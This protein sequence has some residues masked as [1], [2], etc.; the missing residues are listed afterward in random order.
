MLMHIIMMLISKKMKIVEIMKTMM[1]VPRRVNTC[2]HGGVLQPILS[3]FINIAPLVQPIQC[4]PMQPH[5]ISAPPTIQ[6]LLRSTMHPCPVTA[7]PTMQP[8]QSSTVQHM[9]SSP[10]Q[11]HPVSVSPAMFF[12]QSS[13][14]SATRC[15]KTSKDSATPGWN[16]CDII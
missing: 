12:L 13:P 1:H 9:K 4:R 15:S 3:S 5:P 8:L 7:S 11:P 14:L 6:P 10:M 2:L 16:E